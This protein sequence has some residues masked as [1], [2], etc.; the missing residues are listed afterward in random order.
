MGR[1]ARKEADNLARI[2]QGLDPTPKKRRTN[3]VGA[4]V[5]AVVGVV[6]AGASIA[7]QIAAQAAL[8]A[9]KQV[10]A[11]RDRRQEKHDIRRVVNEDKILDQQEA[12]GMS[13][14]GELLGSVGRAG[15]SAYSARQARRSQPGVGMV[16]AAGPV[17]GGLARIGS[18]FGAG[19]VIRGAGT[20]AGK[21]VGWCR[22][23]PGRCAALGGLTA[24]EALLSSGGSLPRSGR[25]RGITSRELRSFRRVTKIISKYCS[26]VRKAMRSP[27]LK[28]GR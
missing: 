17:M 20:Y 18:A 6:T 21:A 23:N 7:V 25:S 1:R 10:K 12:I 4:I 16:G 24:I 19:S 9:A 27:A 2:A 11:R 13:A 28:K 5:S 8:A 22:R 15:V 26:P 14:W 3:I